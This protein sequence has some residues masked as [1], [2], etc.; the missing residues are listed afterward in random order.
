[1]SRLAASGRLLLL[2]PLL[3]WPQLLVQP[4]LM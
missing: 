2:L 3:L 4:L 1:V